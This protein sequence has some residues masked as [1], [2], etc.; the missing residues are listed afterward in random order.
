MVHRHQTHLGRAL[1]LHLHV[2]RRRPGSTSPALNEA[3]TSC[4]Y[5]PCTSKGRESAA[6]SLLGSIW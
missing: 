4:G 6:T 5:S 2:H 3:L 1:G